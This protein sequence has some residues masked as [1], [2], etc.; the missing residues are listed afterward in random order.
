MKKITLLFTIMCVS[1]LNSMESEVKPT[2][3]SL[4]AELK[5]H[6]INTALALGNNLPETIKIIKSASAL[7]G[8]NY[9]DTALVNALMK[10]FPDTVKGI[11][12]FALEKPELYQKVITIVTKKETFKT[13]VDDLKE[14]NILQD[15][16]K[17][18]TVLVHM[19]QEYRTKQL[20][21]KDIADIF[22]TPLAKEYIRLGD[23][24]VEASTNNVLT[25]SRELIEQGA[26]INYSST[27]GTPLIVAAANGN[28][29]LVTLLLN[30]GANPYIV[31]TS[32]TALDIVTQILE[33]QRPGK[34]KLEEIKRILEQGMQNYPL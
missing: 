5:Q 3:R 7:H 27:N 24:L 11:I 29:E 19:I 14:E 25:I 18:F 20:G 22:R 16:L 33:L 21:T 2:Y 9:N 13:I 8:I 12:V 15:N 28:I 4:P 34:E 6:I 31:F 26:D 30:A 1:A 32:R 17:G 23:S 10:K